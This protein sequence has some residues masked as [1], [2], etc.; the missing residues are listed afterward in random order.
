[1]T[2]QSYNEQHTMSTT[3]QHIEVLARGLVIVRGRALLCRD[4]TGGYLYLP[5]GHVEPN[6]PAAEAVRREFIEETGRDVRVGPL[7]LCGEQLFTQSGRP[8]ASGEPRPAKRRHEINLIFAAELL[9]ISGDAEP[10]AT[11]PSGAEPAAGMP[12][13]ISREDH[14]AFDWVELAAAT[15]L[16]IRPASARALLVAGGRPLADA[17]AEWVSERG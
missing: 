4:R 12:E 5:G 11:P 6:E 15:D 17:A 16:D 1:V 13:V 14:L 9:P 8:K 10:A 7:L 2:P 3:P